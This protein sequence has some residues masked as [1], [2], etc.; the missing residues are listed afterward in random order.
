MLELGLVGKPNTGK[1]TFFNAATLSDAPTAGYPFTTVDAN[2]GVTYVRNKCPCQEFGV[3][4]NPQNSKCVGGTRYVPV[5][6]IDVAGLVEGAYK[7]KGLGNQFLDN[8][9]RAGALIHLI[10]A[11]GATDG[12]GKPCPPGTHD[13]V[14]DVGF[15]ENEI[16]RWL[17]SILVKGWPRFARK[18]RLEGRSLS[19]SVAERL[20]GLEIK[21]HHVLTA[22]RSVGLDRESPD[23]W[24]KE[25][26]SHF[27]SELRK[28]SK[29]IMLSANKIDL[30]VASENVERL[31]KLGR[32][33]VPTSAESELALRRADERELI[34][35]EP[36]ASGFEILKRGKLSDDQMRAL[37]SI[38]DLLD[39]W[40]STGVQQVIDEAIYNL[41]GM[42]V[43]YPVDDE[44]R[45]TDKKGN[46]LPDAFL[47]PKDTTAREF[48]YQIHS[49]L[50]DSFIHG[51]DA[52]S[53][54]RIGED[55]KLKDGD[56]IRIVAAAGR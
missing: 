26:L 48:A 50:G 55:Y 41:L 44:N 42:M 31:S 8:L 14:E 45:L 13:P 6:I 46:V 16:D 17:H 35:Y 32:L 24:S 38:K 15:L 18:I 10:D 4:C 28:A 33:T 21:R 23:E 36:G 3:E 54:R 43:V 12:D 29:P 52:K 9:R 39:K 22:L 20:S 47:V 19:R 5:R 53:G 40:G 27:A 1:S 2:I 56:V 11:A 34:K 25:D 7:G 30:S 49:D 37:D 51:I